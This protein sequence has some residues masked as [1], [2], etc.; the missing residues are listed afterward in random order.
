MLVRPERIVDRGLVD[1]A[2]VR[3]SAKSWGPRAKV[4][5]EM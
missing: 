5:L 4:A 1:G 3:A 2:L